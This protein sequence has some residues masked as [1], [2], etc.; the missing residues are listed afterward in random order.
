MRYKG[1]KVNFISNNQFK[2]I[3]KLSKII[4]NFQKRKAL[5]IIKKNA[6]KQN[7]NKIIIESQGKNK[8]KKKQ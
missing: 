1:T 7:L 6:F 8:F 3:H 4:L 2:K 5:M